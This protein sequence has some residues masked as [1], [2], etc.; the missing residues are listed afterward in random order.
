M[1]R[2]VVLLAV[3]LFP[4]SAQDFWDYNHAELNWY[5]YNT[6]HFTVHYHEGTERTALLVGKIAEDIHPHLTGLYNFEPKNRIHFVIK[7]TDDYSNGGAFF[8]DN[9]I[10]IF[11]SN[12]DYV[13]RGTRNWLRDVV[14]HEYAH[15]ISIQKMI[16]TNTTF[17]YGFFQLFGYEKERR[18]DVVRGF[19]NTLISYPISSINLPVWFAEGTAQ[20]QA[21]SSRYDY[22]DPHREMILRDRIIYDRLLTYN[23]MGVFGK[24]SHGNESGYNLGFSFVNYLTD[25]FGEDI[26]AEICT[27]SS[28]WKS[29][30]FNSVVRKATGHE[31]HELYA[32]WRDS[33]KAVY[34]NRLETIRENLVTGTPVEREGFSNLYPVWSPDG[35]KIAWISN[36]GKDY[37]SQNALYIYDT[38][39]ETSKKHVPRISSSLSWSPDGRYIAYARHDYNSRGSAF[40]DLYLYN[41]DEEKEFRLTR[42]LRGRN[43]DFSSDGSK[44]VFVTENNGLFQLNLYHLPEDPEADNPEKNVYVEKETGRFKDTAVNDTDYRTV[45][46]QAGKM[47]QLLAFDISRQIFHPRWSNDDRKIVFDTAV[48]YGRNIGAYDMESERFELLL[49]AEEELRYPA[50]RPGSPWLYYAGSTTGIYNI[51][52]YHMETGETEL[53]TNVTG[54]AFMPDVTAEGKLVYAF[55]DSLGYK[56]NKLDSPEPLNQATALYNPGYIASIPDKNFD[57]TILP[58]YQPAPY[59]RVF[60]GIHILPRILVDYGTVKPGFYMYS[61]DVLDRIN[62]FAGAAVNSDFDYDLYA[63]LEYREIWPIVFAEIYNISAHVPDT[64]SISRGNYSL[65]FEREVSFNL[66][67]ARIGIRSKLPPIW[68]WK[69]EYIFSRYSAKLD[70]SPS[71]DPFR[72]EYWV[73][74]TTRYTYLKGQ[75]VQWSIIA[76]AV[77]GDRNSSINPRGGFY[78]N[79]KHAYEN[80]QFLTEFATDRSIGLEVYDRF[81]YNRF[82]LDGE[83]YF[84]NPLLPSHGMG[85]RVLGGYIDRKVD[86]FFNFFAGGLIGMKGYSFYSIEGRQ[87]LITTFSYRFPLMRNIDRRL[88]HIYFDKLYFGLFY[89]YGHAWDGESIPWKSFQRDVGVQLRLET[90]SYHLFPTRLFAE[91]AYPLDEVTNEDVLYN[92]EWHFYFGALFEYD[93]RER[94]KGFSKLNPMR[95]FK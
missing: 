75:A 63:N 18:K 73:L 41:V 77:K 27:I 59:Q 69:L 72:K 31:G 67:E 2:I 39:T 8:F 23:E 36:K 6:E 91:A 43:P 54:G 57:D 53:L 46:Y 20:H 61:A 81:E 5:S 16:K 56:I 88:G 7:D 24:N 85:I 38:E 4:L 94:L 64:L 87:K 9:K 34:D 11:A 95:V 83:M 84:K 22:R 40:T 26:L 74:P 80:N 12:L 19:P 50:F 30:T 21:D 52:R 25:R 51:Y 82:E 68:S 42:A 92:K 76:D 35:K 90:F 93:F 15:M 45:T 28:D 65:D 78:L 1:T 79:F 13:M 3:L 14:T 29:Y 37:F 86:D 49:E 62:L 47:E 17:P 48:E 70:L 58:D 89:D 33:L 60:N 32:D 71:F 44:L 10:E 55:Y 66:T